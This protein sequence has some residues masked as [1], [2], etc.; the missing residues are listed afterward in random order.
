MEK[1][2]VDDSRERLV[3]AFYFALG[4]YT[5]QEATKLDEWREASLGQLYAHLLHEVKEEIR[6]N[7]KRSELTYLV[8][9]AVDAVALSTILLARVM[10]MAGCDG[11]DGL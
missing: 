8:H 9:N 7:I 6:G 3:R 5:E 1:T 2:R 4:A 11:E 10:E